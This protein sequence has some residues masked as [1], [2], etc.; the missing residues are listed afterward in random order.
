[1]MMGTVVFDKMPLRMRMLVL[2][3]DKSVEIHKR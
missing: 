1:M 3:S 2:Q